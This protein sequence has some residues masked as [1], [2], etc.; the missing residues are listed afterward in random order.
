MVSVREGGR[1]KSLADIRVDTVE[2]WEFPRDTRDCSSKSF[3]RLF[4][5][6]TKCDNK[7]LKPL[8]SLE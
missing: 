4:Y 6:G 3:Y 7:V 1:V 8:L 5:F 2:F